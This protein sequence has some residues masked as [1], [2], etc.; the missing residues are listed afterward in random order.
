MTGTRAV[1]SIGVGVVGLGL[2]ASVMLPVIAR[3]TRFALRTATDLQ[4]VL[5]DRFAATYDVPATEDLAGLLA[6]ADVDVVYIATP[7]QLHAEQAILAARAG[8]HVVVEKPMALT[9]AECDAMI[10]AAREAGTILIVGHTH[11]FDPAIGAIRAFADQPDVGEP[12]LLNGFNYTNFLYRPRRP[13]E[14]DPDQGGGVLWN[15]IPHQVDIARLIIDRPVRA[16][17]AVLH[18]LDPARRVDG[19]S[20]MFL[21]FEG[22]ASAML[23][24]SGYD[25]FDSDEWFD[26]VSASG[27]AK[28]PAHGAAVRAL[29]PA[30]EHA[31]RQTRWSVGGGAVSNGDPVGQPHFG[32]LIVSCERADI[33]TTPHGLMIY[34]RSGVREIPLTLEG[35]RPGHRAVWDEFVS[36]LA[37]GRAPL[38]DGVF[39]RATVAVCLAIAQSARLGET[40]RIPAVAGSDLP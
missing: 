39:A 29:D 30:R 21:D 15:Q 18:A 3:D 4:P 10:A 9:L 8:K 37:D 11:G 2:A 33:R 27:T 13:D 22:A 6:R 5:R 12:L 16:V 40:V 20:A 1:D 19:L 26:W 25:R 23:V 35:E 7:P 36:A 14:L 28:T 17:R 34:D 32:Q 31:E 24:Y 38:H